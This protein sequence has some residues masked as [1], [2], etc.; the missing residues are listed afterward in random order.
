V[1][2]YDHRSLQDNINKGPKSGN[3]HTPTRPLYKEADS[4]YSSKNLHNQGS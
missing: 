4:L 1:P 3:V 2:L